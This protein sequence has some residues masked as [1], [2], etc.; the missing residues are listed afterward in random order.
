MTFGITLGKY[1]VMAASANMFYIAIDYNNKTYMKVGAN[2]INIEINQL[3]FKQWIPSDH[4][5]SVSRKISGDLT[6]TCF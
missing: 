5:T 6:R 2:N 3:F 4:G 1:L